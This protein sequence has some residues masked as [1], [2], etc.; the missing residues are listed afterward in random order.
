M[1]STY[2]MLKT[3]YQFLETE[4]KNVHIYVIEFLQS[5]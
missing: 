5:A 2:E 3:N 1:D 4:K